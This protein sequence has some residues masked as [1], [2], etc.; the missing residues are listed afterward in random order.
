MQINY[1]D[2]QSDKLLDAVYLPCT[3][4]VCMSGVGE[5]VVMRRGEECILYCLRGRDPRT[6]QSLIY[7]VISLS[8]GCLYMFVVCMYVHYCK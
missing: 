6:V 1:I 4:G 3:S 8:I 7:F 5:L 2:L